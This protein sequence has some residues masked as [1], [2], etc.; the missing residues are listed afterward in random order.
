MVRL[1]FFFGLRGLGL[2]FFFGPIHIL[3]QK[4]RAHRACRGGSLERAEQLPSRVV[5]CGTLCVACLST[6]KDQSSSRVC[7]DQ[8]PEPGLSFLHTSLS[9]NILPFFNTD[10]RTK[11]LL[12]SRRECAFLCVA[13]NPF[14]TGVSLIP[15]DLF[16]KSGSAVLIGVQQRLFCFFHEAGMVALPSNSGVAPNFGQRYIQQYV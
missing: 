3:L 8:M 16:E 15:S 2:F 11:R 4:A 7:A 5:L 9:G 12:Y 10:M 6:V 13:L 14:R 1:T